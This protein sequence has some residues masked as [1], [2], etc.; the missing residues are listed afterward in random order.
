MKAEEERRKQ[1]QREQAQAAVHI[2]KVQRGKA[3]RKA[4]DTWPLRKR[5]SFEMS[6]ESDGN[7]LVVTCPEM[8]QHFSH[9]F[10]KTKALGRGWFGRFV[11]QGSGAVHTSGK[12]KRRRK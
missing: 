7:I 10:P 12:L 4:A 5:R 2:Q 1:V 8:L 11:S 9:H 3:G 6:S